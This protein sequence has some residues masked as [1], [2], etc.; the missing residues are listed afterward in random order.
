MSIRTMALALLAGATLLCAAAPAA[1]AQDAQDA[2]DPAAFVQ[3]LHFRSGT[4]EVPAAKARF[5][6]GPEFQY[7]DQ[8]D[9][10]R[11]YYVVETAHGQRG[12]AFRERNDPHAPWM[13]HGW[14]G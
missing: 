3:S 8:A 10:R 12:W 7:L 5:N 13:L 9:A 2:P 1:H 11:D 4:I 14:F 6:L